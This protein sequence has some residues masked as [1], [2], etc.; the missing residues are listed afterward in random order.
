MMARR[1]VHPL[2]LAPT[3]TS[4]EN[5]SGCVTNHAVPW[6]EIVNEQPSWKSQM[7]PFGGGVSIP[8]SL[9]HHLPMLMDWAADN[10]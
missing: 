2:S 3:A 9:Q 8:A 1:I 10:A 5:L 6:L 7:V 4:E